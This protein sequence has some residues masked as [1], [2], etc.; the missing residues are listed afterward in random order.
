MNET[1]KEQ[2]LRTL[3]DGWHKWVCI[4]HSHPH[5]FK[6]GECIRCHKLEN[7]KNSYEKW[8]KINDSLYS[9][10]SKC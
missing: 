7:K 5:I 6:N 8:S 4:D 3:E 9:N 1:E 10:I 2:K